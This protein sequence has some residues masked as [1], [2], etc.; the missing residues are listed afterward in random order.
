[1]VNLPCAHAAVEQVVF[2][3]L[4]ETQKAVYNQYLSS[5]DVKQLLR[6]SSLTGTSSLQS[7]NILKKLCNRMS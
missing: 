4:T 3:R 7:I 6:D 5:K 2:C 1:M